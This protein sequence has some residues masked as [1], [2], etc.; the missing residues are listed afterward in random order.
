MTQHILKAIEQVERNAARATA[1]LETERAQEAERATGAPPSTRSVWA[2]GTPSVPFGNPPLIMSAVTRR[3]KV[4]VAELAAL[5]VT[6]SVKLNTPDR[7]WHAGGN[8][9]PV[10]FK[11][12]VNTLVVEAG[13]RFFLSV[14]DTD[15]W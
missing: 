10:E 1:R 6:R 15:T 12:G 2:Y 5:S 8:R 14:T 4:R 3:V 11:D 9:I 13:N 7:G